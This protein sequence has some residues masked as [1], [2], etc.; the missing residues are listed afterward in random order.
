MC[1]CVCGCVWV[2]G[3]VC[4]LG[5]GLEVPDQS[6]VPSIR[7]GSDGSPG[8]GPILGHRMPCAA[9]GTPN[10]WTNQALPAYPLP[11]PMHLMRSRTPHR[12][13]RRRRVDPTT[14]DVHQACSKRAFDGQVKKWRR[15]LH[16]WDQSEDEPA[17]VAL[18]EASMEP[19]SS[20]EGSAGARP[21]AGPVSALAGS[22][23][24]RDAHFS[25]RGRPRLRL[26]RP[27]PGC[28][29]GD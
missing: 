22:P 12:S 28:R 2:C 7:L 6:C 3:R 9:A 17:G 24:A 14:P 8:L 21:E 11:T 13:K 18:K 25:T 15:E 23:G 10:L 19:A 20:T 4:V 26:G 1:G 27:A 16:A 5:G 29:V